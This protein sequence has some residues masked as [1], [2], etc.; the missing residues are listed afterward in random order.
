MKKFTTALLIL[1]LSACAL[2]SSED[3]LYRKVLMAI[4][5]QKTEKISDTDYENILEYLSKGQDRWINLYPALDKEPFLSI[6]YF[7]EGLHIS[8][9]EA[10]INNA[11]GT[12]QYLNKDN[13]EHICGIPFIE[14]TVEEIDVYYIKARAALKAASAKSGWKELCILQLE[15]SYSGFQN[16][17][18]PTEGKAFCS[19]AI[20]YKF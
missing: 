11:T 14:P 13:I 19:K 3:K 6:T 1:L 20:F 18:R 2:N 12:L 5:E 7:Q 15:N 9:A 17:V 4:N 8:M 16:M 10:L